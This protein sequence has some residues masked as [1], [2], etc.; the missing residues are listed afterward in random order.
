MVRNLRLIL[1]IGIGLLGAAWIAR[2]WTLYRRIPLNYEWNAAGEFLKTQASHDDLLLFEPNW[3]AGFAQDH[4]RLKIYSVVT[5][6]EIFKKTYPPASE[7]WLVSIFPKSSVAQRAQKAG[8]VV[9]ETHPIYSI[10]LTRCSIPARNL[11]FSF[12]DHLAQARVFIDY[13]DENVMEAQ[14]QGDAWVFSDNPIDWNQVSVRTE[15]FRR[16]LRRCIWLHPLEGGIKTIEYSGVPVGKRME[17][18]GGIVDSGLRTPPGAPVNL[19]MGV[20]GSQVGNFEFHDT[21]FSFWRLIDTSSVSGENRRVS[22]QIL[23][24]EEAGRHFCFSAWS[25]KE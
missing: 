1:F 9:E 19:R 18:F 22:F 20:E 6:Q 5:E 10:F 2:Q 17:L 11:T 13:G 15:A 8:F 21:D 7:L 14:R 24:S 12:T 23:T 16:R 4:G 25:L 3:L